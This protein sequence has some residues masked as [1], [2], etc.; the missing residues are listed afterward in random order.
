[1]PDGRVGLWARLSGDEGGAE[2]D[3]FFSPKRQLN[4]LVKTLFWQMK[5]QIGKIDDA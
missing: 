2:T 4:A 5:L 3:M 1:M